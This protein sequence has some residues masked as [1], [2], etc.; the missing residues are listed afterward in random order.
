MT[1]VLRVHIPLGNDA[2]T[3]QMFCTR[4]DEFVT[5]CWT[6]LGTQVS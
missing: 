5:S 6:F 3:G 4:E 2:H 1:F